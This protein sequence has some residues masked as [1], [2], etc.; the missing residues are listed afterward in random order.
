MVAEQTK[1]ILSECGIPQHVISDNGI[2]FTGEAY[3]LLVCTWG[4]LTRAQICPISNVKRNTGT[5]YQNSEKYT[6]QI[7]ENWYR[8]ILGNAINTSYPHQ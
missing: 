2:Q 8:P 4:D 3:Q 7:S 1:Q 5:G 6:R